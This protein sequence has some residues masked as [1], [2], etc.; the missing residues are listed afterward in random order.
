[1]PQGIKF[2]EGLT[3]ITWFLL[4]LWF[5]ITHADKNIQGPTDFHT[6]IYFNTSHYVHTVATF[7]TLN[8]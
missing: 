7:V 2:T 8:E 1:M 5:D 6:H 4:V 3:Q